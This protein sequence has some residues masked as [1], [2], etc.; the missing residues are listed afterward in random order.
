MPVVLPVAE[1]ATAHL[2]DSEDE[3][4]EHDFTCQ[5]DVFFKER[6]PR[7]IPDWAYHDDVQG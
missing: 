1:E 2:D 7:Y 6:H 4:A 5:L 3:A